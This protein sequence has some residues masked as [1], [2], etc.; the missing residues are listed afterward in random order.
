MSRE[1]YKVK[2]CKMPRYSRVVYHQKGTRT[3]LI[4]KMTCPRNTAPV[5]L[6]RCLQRKRGYRPGAVYR[7]GGDDR[8]R[9]PGG[10]AEYRGPW[11]HLDDDAAAAG[12]RGYTVGSASTTAPSLVAVSGRLTKSREEY[13]RLGV[14]VS[15]ILRAEGLIGLS[16]EPRPTRAWPGPAAWIGLVRFVAPRGSTVASFLLLHSCTRR[17]RRNRRLFLCG[18][19][20]AHAGWCDK[21]PRPGAGPWATRMVPT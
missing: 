10:G 6:S 2:Q 19:P 13:D 8:A 12:K 4:L 5:S 3:P 14:C 21:E 7:P 20:P 17:T 9:G 18:H 11:E 16:S 1:I 15:L